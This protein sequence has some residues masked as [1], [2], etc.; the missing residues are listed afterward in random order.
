MKIHN[1]LLFLLAFYLTS[2]AQTFVEKEQLGDFTSASAFSVSPS[3][4]IY[5]SD[6]QTNEITKL[7]S[8]GNAIKTIGGYGWDENS[9]DNP[10]D[11]YA[12]VLQVYVADKNNN[13]IQP[14]PGGRGD[15]AFREA[16]GRDSEVADG[17]KGQDHT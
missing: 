16:G 15:N 8:I 2:Y 13:R 3:L 11:I 7:D 10:V 6:S 17:K 4:H 12:N 14:A 5:V 9:F 1:Y